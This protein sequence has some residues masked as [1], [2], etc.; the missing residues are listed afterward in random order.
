M[1]PS[2]QKIIPPT[3]KRT[4]FFQH[5]QTVLHGI[6]R[7]DIIK[8]VNVLWH[9]IKKCLDFIKKIGIIRGV[10]ADNMGLSAD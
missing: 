6:R 10:P 8:S 4:I 7:F 5:G 9:R 2:Q 1:N 3:K